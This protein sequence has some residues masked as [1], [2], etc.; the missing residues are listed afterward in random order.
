MK[1]GKPTTFATLTWKSATKLVLGLPGNPVSATVTCHLYVLPL[2]RTMSGHQRPFGAVVQARLPFDVDLDPRPEYFRVS[3]S[4]ATDS[5]VA[6]VQ[7]TG[8]QVRIV[9]GAEY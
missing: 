3:L 4:W 6:N 2:A 8:N 7:A 5:P 1:P 9:K